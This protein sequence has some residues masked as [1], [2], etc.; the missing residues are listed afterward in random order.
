MKGR[1][2]Y[3]WRGS[4]IKT[5][6]G[7]N[8]RGLVPWPGSWWWRWGGEPWRCG[9]AAWPDGPAGSPFSE[10][11]AEMTSKLKR[12]SLEDPGD[13]QAGSLTRTM[14]TCLGYG[15]ACL[16]HSIRAKKL[17]SWFEDKLTLGSLGSY[18]IILNL[19]SD[20]TF[21]H[22]DPLLN[23]CRSQ[24]GLVYMTIRIQIPRFTPIPQFLR[25]C[26]PVNWS[27]Q[28][29]LHLV[30]CYLCRKNTSVWQQQGSICV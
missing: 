23:A 7:G 24:I 26:M 8:R 29:L 18:I 19:H 10:Q 21:Q 16:L 6:S 2:K 12:L 14:L 15:T 20:P 9:E 13:T 17:K 4:R 22:V 25:A 3:L 5:S 27:N 28:N 11:A 1:E 30:M